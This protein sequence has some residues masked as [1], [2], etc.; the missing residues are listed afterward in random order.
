MIFPYIYRIMTIPNPEHPGWLEITIQIDPVAHEALSAFLFDLGCEGIV[1]GDCPDHMLKAY[2]TFFEDNLAIHHQIHAF[3]KNLQ[4]IFREIPPPKVFLDKIE[5]QD[6]SHNWRQFFLPEPITRDLTVLPVWESL[7]HI[8][9]KHVIRMDPGPAFGTGQH[10]T[11][12][13]CLRA[14]EKVPRPRS[15][16]MLDVGTGSGILAIYGA[17]L[18]ANRVTAIDIDPE[19]IRWAERNILLNEVSGAIVLSCNP[20]QS[21]QD[22]FFILTANL[23]LGEILNLFSQFKRVLKPWGWLIL[24]GILREQVK[25]IEERLKHYGFLKQE[26]LYQQE[27]SCLIA[28]KTD[29]EAEI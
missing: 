16:N 11:T 22:K 18:G 26:V 17:K 14:M 20:L 13:M 4:E 23:I 10:P 6:W 9:N 19:A 24:S 25:G 8:V 12:R 2:I 29:T 1:S 5:N 28:R 21:I 7:P 3:L 27:W 15:W